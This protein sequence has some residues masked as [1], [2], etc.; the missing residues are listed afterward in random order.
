M[1]EKVSVIV[2]V[3]NVEQYLDRCVES[4]V[5]QTYKDLEIILVDDGSP[6]NCPQK[7]DEW[8]IRDARI[9]V[10]HKDNGGLSSARNT[11]LDIAKGDYISFVDSDDYIKPN[12][13]EKM[14]KMAAINSSQVVCCGRVRESANSKKELF[15]L[16]EEKTFSGEQAIK[17]LLIGGCVEEAA[18]DKIYRAEVFEK[19]RFP[20]GEINEDIVQTIEILGNCDKVCHVGEAL[21][22]YCEN[23]GSITKSG[24]KQNKIVIL[25]HLDQIKVY[26]EENV[27][28][29]LEY[30]YVLETR[31]C[32]SILYLL[33]GDKETYRKY[34]KE[35]RLFYTRFRKGFSKRYV[36]RYIG[37]SELIK[38][39]LIYLRAYYWIHELK[40]GKN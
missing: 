5:N 26:L 13:I 12:M 40:A 32:Q 6:D 10:V 33:L 1:N 29:L 14:V 9:I 3:Y 36:R 25:K 35:Y 34:Q 15:V 4:I 17:E 27:P 23:L 19:R 38:G 31:Y 30:Y 11:G 21:Y 28:S 39:W 20:L 2:P 37:K 18:W 8:K 16:S 7:C 24:Y 22:Y